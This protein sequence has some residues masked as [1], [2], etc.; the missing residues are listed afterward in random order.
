MK[1]TAIVIAIVLTNGGV[2]DSSAQD[3][4]IQRQQR[5]PIPTKNTNKYHYKV[6]LINHKIYL[7]FLDDDS[8]K[9][10]PFEKYN[11]NNERYIY[12]PKDRPQVF[13]SA[14]Q[15]FRQRGSDKWLYT[16]NWVHMRASRVEP[17]DI[18]PNKVAEKANTEQPA[19]R[20]VSES[21]SS[22]KT[23]PDAEEHSQ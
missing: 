12:I 22:D 5:K 21:K 3:A 7:R 20:P 14:M 13:A 2:T 17:N 23:Q 16:D 9:I 8:K 6:I 11:E 4:P 18:L 1:T 15:I 10:G 19:T